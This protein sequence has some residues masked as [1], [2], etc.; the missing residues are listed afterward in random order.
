MQS[1]SSK[2]EKRET[3]RG[4]LCAADI[5]L[6]TYFTNR[7]NQLKFF[8]YGNGK[9]IPG[10]YAAYFSFQEGKLQ[11]YRTEWNLDQWFSPDALSQFKKSYTHVA[12]ENIPPSIYCFAEF[13]QLW[14]NQDYEDCVLV[15]KA[16][17]CKK[18]NTSHGSWWGY[19]TRL[20]SGAQKGVGKSVWLTNCSAENIK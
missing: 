16:V 14:R 19:G 3:K 15:R 4:C 12:N 8:S 9:S 2:K 17:S 5:E 11:C 10:L 7:F 1:K 18:V 13:N 6:C 20:N